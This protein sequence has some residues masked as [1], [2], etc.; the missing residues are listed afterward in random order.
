MNRC[1]HGHNCPA[2]QRDPVTTNFMYVGAGVIFMLVCLIV[3]MIALL[4]IFDRY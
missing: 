3:F 4:E 1:P 2:R